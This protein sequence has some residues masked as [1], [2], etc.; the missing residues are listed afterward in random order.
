VKTSAQGDGSTFEVRAL[1]GWGVPTVEFLVTPHEV[2][3]RLA[4]FDYYGC[5]TDVTVRRTSDHELIEL[6][7]F[8]FH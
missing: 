7:Y 8:T 2:A 5:Y 1:D 6:A 3:L 4:E